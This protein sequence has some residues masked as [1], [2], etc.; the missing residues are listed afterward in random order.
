MLCV[1]YDIVFYKG[2][3]IS[4]IDWNLEYREK[5]WGLMSFS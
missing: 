3:T 5:M 4:D 2:N 1:Y